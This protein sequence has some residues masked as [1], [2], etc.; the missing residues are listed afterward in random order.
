ML[1]IMGLQSRRCRKSYEWNNY[2]I[3][4]N[5]D[6]SSF[7]ADKS[8]KQKEL[9]LVCCINFTNYSHKNYSNLF[10]FMIYFL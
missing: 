3:S 10:K 8:A 9:T 1:E 4:K 2:A 6:N 5:K 7:L